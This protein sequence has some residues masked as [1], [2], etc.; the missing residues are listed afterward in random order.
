M[1]SSSGHSSTWLAVSR[2]ISYA[3]RSCWAQRGQEREV[4]RG[5]WG[6]GSRVSGHSGSSPAAGPAVQPPL[7]PAAAP[8]AVASAA[9]ASGRQHPPSYLVEV[10]ALVAQRGLGD[11]VDLTLL[12]LRLPA[13]ALQAGGAGAWAGGRVG[14]CRGRAGRAGQ[15]SSISS[16]SR[17]HAAPA[18]P[19][20]PGCPAPSRLPPG[21]QAPT[22]SFQATTRISPPCASSRSNE[23]KRPSPRALLYLQAAGVVVGSGHG[24]VTQAAAGLVGSQRQ[25][26]VQAPRPAPSTRPLHA[27]LHHPTADAH[28][29]MSLLLVTRALMVHRFW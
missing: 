24:W 16:S 15:G 1:S 8:A 12:H 11:E 25:D 22:W 13:V 19:P 17:P 4:G 29:R 27:P 28:R 7:S 5:A 26:G 21:A 14:G 10:A 18:A 9:A 20:M 6:L 23:K 2:W 3:C